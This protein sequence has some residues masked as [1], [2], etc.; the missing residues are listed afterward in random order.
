MYN[1]CGSPA[2]STATSCY[3][4]SS[5][6]AWRLLLLLQAAALLLNNLSTAKPM[7]QS[8]LAEALQDG[9]SERRRYAKLLQ[10]LLPPTQ[11]IPNELLQRL[12]CRE[13]ISPAGASALSRC[14]CAPV[15]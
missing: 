13:G 5:P 7:P 2:H 12:L 10:P 15:N 9:R 1:H 6:L 11:T 3:S 4:S 8:Q 14:Y